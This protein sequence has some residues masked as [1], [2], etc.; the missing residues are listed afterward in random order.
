[1]TFVRINDD[2]GTG[3]KGAIGRVLNHAVKDGQEYVEVQV[4]TSSVW[5][6]V[7]GV[8]P[9]TFN[10]ETQTFDVHQPH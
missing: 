4:Y 8:S 9:A 5:V 1:M 3:T 10:H 6:N 7:T 2:G